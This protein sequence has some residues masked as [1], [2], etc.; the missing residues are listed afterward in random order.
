MFVISYSGGLSNHLYI[1][2]LPDD[3]KTL[4]NEPHRVLVRIYGDIIREDHNMAL[5]DAVVFA[6]LAEKRIGPK[7]HGVFPDG[8]IEEFVE[9]GEFLLNLTHHA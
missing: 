6:L 9:V 2:T 1:C 7:L 8:R 4:K 3:V 5:T